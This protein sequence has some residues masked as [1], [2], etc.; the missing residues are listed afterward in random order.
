M[1]E[2]DI[3]RRFNQRVRR[4]KKLKDIQ[5]LETTDNLYDG[6]H[7]I[8]CDYLVKGDTAK[9]L[10]KICSKVSCDCPDYESRC[11]EHDIPCKHILWV[12]R[13]HIGFNGNIY[14]LAT[15]KYSDVFLISL[16][17]KTNYQDAFH[18]AD[19]L[20]D[21]LERGY[22]GDDNLADADDNGEW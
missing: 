4:S 10:V 12:M 21:N 20:D 19:N 6:N 3:T 2:E 7:F 5:V 16:D 18:V 13:E 8:G 9:Y 17:F 11:E 22:D 14:D 15:L 1:T